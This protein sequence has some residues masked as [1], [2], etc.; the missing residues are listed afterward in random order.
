MLNRNLIFT[1]TALS[2]ALVALGSSTASSQV[3][4]QSTGTVSGTIQLPS[5]NP[6][7]NNRVTRVDTNKS[8]TYSRNGTPVYTSNYVKVQTN[9]D[10]SLKYYVDFKGI[11]VISFDGLLTSPALSGGK[12][13]PYTY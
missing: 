2:A 6:N 13:T 1:S 5:F 8:G 4:I 3:T 10:G 9:A 12:L 11:P 7:F